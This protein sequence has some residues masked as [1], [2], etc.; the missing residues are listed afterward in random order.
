[1]NPW[2]IMPALVVLAV[3]Y[4]LLPVGAA[5]STRYRRAKLVRCP[6]TGRKTALRVER[7]GVAE[8]LG[9]RSLRRV[10]YCSLWPERRNC[11]QACLEL[12]EERIREFRA[13][14]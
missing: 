1:M 3:I 5:M 4:V 12:P 14:V 13:G 9:R 11:S 6:L 2:L 8:A 7:A 10:S